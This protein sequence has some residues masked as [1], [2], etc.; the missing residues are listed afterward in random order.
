MF[1]NKELDGF[2]Y[3]GFVYSYDL[4]VSSDNCKTDHFVTKDGK[5]TEMDWSPYSNPSAED[6][7]L[8][9][10]LGMPRRVGIGPLNERDLANLKLKQGLK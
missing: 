7:K 5:R 10:D 6:F 1:G 8:W 9:I 3:Q 4:E 2:E